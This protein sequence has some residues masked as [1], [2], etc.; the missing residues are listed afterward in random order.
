MA[1][2]T[3]GSAQALLHIGA[4]ESVVRVG[5]ASGPVVHMA[6]GYAGVPA[7]LF[8]GD[9]P[10]ALELEDAVAAV[11]DEVMPVVRQLADVTEL[12]TTDPGLCALTAAARVDAEGVLPVERIEWLFDELSRA[13]LGGPVSGL[14]FTPSKRWAAT[15]LILRELMHH[16]GIR[17]L[18]INRG[19]R[20]NPSA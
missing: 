10:T 7:T 11:E 12:I 20:A 5:G 14:P 6:L 19:W 2:L 16:G 9:I 4:R 3:P 1:E 17:A 15:L 8:R 13:A 18:R